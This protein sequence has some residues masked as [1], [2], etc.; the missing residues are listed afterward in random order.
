MIIPSP[1]VYPD[2]PEVVERESIRL[3]ENASHIF[4]DLTMQ[5]KSLEKE[6]KNSM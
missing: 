1:Q 4:K 3:R 2:M 5:V 6:Q